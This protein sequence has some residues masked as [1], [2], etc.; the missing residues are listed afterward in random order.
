MKINLA[1]LVVSAAFLLASC[2]D[3]VTLAEGG[4]TGTGIT[5]GRIT[6]FGSIYV[7]GIHYDVDNALFYRNDT[8]VSDQSS[9]AAGEFITV[10]GTVNTDGISGVAT[11]VNFDGLVKGKVDAIAADGK[12]ISILGQTIQIDLLSVLH[13]FDLLADLQIGNLVEVSGDRLPS[14]AIK[15]TSLTLLAA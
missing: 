6:G 14:G 8:K 15:A 12:S 4:M 11:Q 3:A 10:T 5:A 9:F 1:A 2:G 7:N 13:G